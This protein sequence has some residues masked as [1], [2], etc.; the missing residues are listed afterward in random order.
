MTTEIEVLREQVASLDRYGRGRRYP[1]PLRE[2][3]VAAIERLRS[4]GATWTSI[5]REFGVMAET[6]RRWLVRMGPEPEG[7]VVPV[8]VSAQQTELAVVSPTG[9]RVEGLNLESAAQLLRL[10]S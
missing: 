4:R 1:A 6:A 5:G 2:R 3:L 9:F 10:L 7:R 8:S